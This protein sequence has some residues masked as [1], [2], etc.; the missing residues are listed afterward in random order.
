MD[1]SMQAP[2]R[3][4]NL[5]PRS[6][7]RRLRIGVL[8]FSATLAAAVVMAGTGT[9]AYARWLLVFPF[10]IATLYI[11]EAMY[12]TCPFMAS[13]GLRDASE[14]PEPIAD[15]GERVAMQAKSRRLL[16]V[17][18]AIAVTAAGLFAQMA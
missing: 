9:P 17:S 2:N 6:Q 12:R 5:G 7:D 1:Q 18:A 16:L 10:F 3:C 15:P 14:G 11:G 8:I 13:R 4:S